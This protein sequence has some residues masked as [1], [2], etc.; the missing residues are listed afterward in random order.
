MPNRKGPAGVVLAYEKLRTAIVEG[1]FRPGERLVEQK[2]AERYDLSRTPIREAIRRLDAEGLVSS[3]RNRGA[4]VREV[5]PDEI[6]D[7]YELRA[8]LESYAAELAAERSTPDEVTELRVAVEGF[9]ALVGDTERLGSLDHVREL[10]DANGTVHSQIVAG[11]HH[12]R[13]ASMLRRTVD[14][15]LVFGAFRN[16]DLGDLQRSDLFHHLIADA[17]E[18]GDGGRAA[19]LMREHIMQ[20]RDTVNLLGQP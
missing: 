3:E 4:I 16:F 2:I 18:R 1:E 12:V 6:H 13:L 17:I 15:P 7:L 5:G 14:I 8:R 19:G 10:N 11:A 9:G 20:G